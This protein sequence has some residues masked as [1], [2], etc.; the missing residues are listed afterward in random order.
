[1]SETKACIAAIKARFNSS[2]PPAKPGKQNDHFE[3]ALAEDPAFLYVK[4]PSSLVY[5]IITILFINYLP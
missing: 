3:K 5:F 4:T 1:M 2:F